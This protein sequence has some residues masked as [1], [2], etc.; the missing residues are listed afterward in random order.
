MKHWITLNEPWCV[1][2][3]G[4]GSGGFPPGRTGDT[5]PYI[6]AHHLLLAHGKAVRRFREGGYG[7]SIGISNN[8]DWREPLTDS[9]EDGRP[10]SGP[11]NSSTAGSPIQWFSATTP[12]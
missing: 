5:E 7:G 11:S 3:L 6:V 10:R 1:S 4:Y 8:C 12:P 2:V 9:P